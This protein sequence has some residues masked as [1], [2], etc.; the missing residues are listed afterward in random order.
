LRHDL[1]SER[2]RIL[3]IESGGLGD[4]VSTIPA[5]RF[6]REQFCHDEITT[7]VPAWYADIAKQMDC[8]DH[9]L[10]QSGSLWKTLRTVRKNEYD[11]VINFQ[12]SRKNSFLTVFSR[13]RGRAGYVVLTPSELYSSRENWYFACKGLKLIRGKI[14]A[15]VSLYDRALGIISILTG[16]EPYHIRVPFVF[17]QT[18]RDKTDMVR[19]YIVLH[20]FSSKKTKNW[21]TGL[22][23][24]FVTMA[25]NEFQTKVIIIG[26]ESDKV[27]IQDLN[28]RRKKEIAIDF[29]VVSMDR[30]PFFLS[31]CMFFVG[32]DSG[33]L[34]LAVGLNVPA[35]G[36]FGRTAPNL[37]F[38]DNM[39]QTRT[40]L[41]YKNHQC[42]CSYK[43]CT[44]AGECMKLIEPSEVVTAAKTLIQS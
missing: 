8:L 12:P 30:L 15:G 34:H 28:S 40:I 4:F 1:A 7:M 29:Q 13:S 27:A 43:N 11:W 6:F 16:K 32:V 35:I 5:I 10:T 38:P 39:F 21:P 25:W 9:V 41:I 36:L 33:P 20:P 3:I 17:P 26:D 19:R 31:E 14:P 24:Q 23:D 37:V 18:H 44:A 2:M 42:H 22:V